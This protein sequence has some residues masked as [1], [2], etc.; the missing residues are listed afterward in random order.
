M[1]INSAVI[2]ICTQR[3]MARASHYLLTDFLGYFEA[4][5]QS[6]ENR[7]GIFTSKDVAAKQL[8]QQTADGLKIS[9]WSIVQCVQF[10]LDL[11]APFVLTEVFNRDILEQ[12]FGHYR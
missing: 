9:V 3:Q 12:H 7:P 5:K 1:K 8:S 6:A 4:W 2:L 10:L 11:G